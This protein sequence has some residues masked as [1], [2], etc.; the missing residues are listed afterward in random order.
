MDDIGLP[1][2][3][4][5][6]YLANSIQQANL[7]ELLLKKTHTLLRLYMI[8]GFNFASRDIGS[9]SDPYLIIKYGDKVYNER[10]NYQL[11]QPNPKFYKKYD[12]DAEFPGGKSLII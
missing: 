7:S 2:L 1:H 8:D 9:P 10:E 12:F 11:N 4:L 3:N 6:N 5:G